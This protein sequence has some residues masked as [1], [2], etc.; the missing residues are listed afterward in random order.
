MKRELPKSG[1]FYRHFKG[2]IYQIIVI[3]K[4]ADTKVCNVVYQ[5]MYEPFSCWVRSA[6]EF[7]SEI[8]RKKYPDASQEFRF[9]KI[10]FANSYSGRCI[11]D[12][13][14]PADEKESIREKEKV[15]T[16]REISSEEFGKAVETGQAIRYL[17]DVMTKEE[18]GQRGL[19]EI[20]DAGSFQK[21]RSLFIGLREYLDKRLLNSIAVALDIVLEDGSEEEQYD[22]LLHCLDAFEHYEGGRLR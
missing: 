4:D 5:G 11:E 21:K 10:T 13:V 12:A 14:L 9:E 8:D 3:A 1:E 19:M 2:K 20:L 18:I 16:K 6:E 15:R 7:L 17:G 22:S